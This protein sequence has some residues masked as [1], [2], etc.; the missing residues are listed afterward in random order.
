M[1]FIVLLES[2]QIWLWGHVIEYFLK[3]HSFLERKLGNRPGLLGWLWKLIH[4]R[5]WQKSSTLSAA[6]W[7]FSTLAIYQLV[8]TLGHGWLWNIAVSLAVD[9]A[10][11]AVSTWIWRK[12][13]IARTKSASSW[14]VVWA[15]FFAFNGVLAWLLMG[16]ANI[17]TLPARGI[18]AC[19]GI[20]MNPVIFMIRD[21]VV[22]GNWRLRVAI[23]PLRV[24]LNGKVLFPNRRP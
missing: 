2:L 10:V 11:W 18:L 20:A 7:I 16:Q 1:R 6:V 14:V 9:A 12:R 5:E 22:F 23:N 15:T 8:A 13:K 17:D 3:V 24:S 4:I 19:Y 21:K